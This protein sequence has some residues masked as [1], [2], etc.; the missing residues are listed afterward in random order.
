MARQRHPDRGER[1]DYQDTQHRPWSGTVSPIPEGRRENPGVRS[2]DSVVEKD[3]IR[4]PN[5]ARKYPAR[6]ISDT[7]NAEPKNAFTMKEVA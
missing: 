7:L 5:R 2:P 6:K 4:I 3:R 1:E